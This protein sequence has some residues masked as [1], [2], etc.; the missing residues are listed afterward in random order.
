MNEK[1]ISI[2]NYITGK[3]VIITDYLFSTVTSPSKLVATSLAYGISADA[4]LVGKLGFIAF[5]FTNIQLAFGILASGGWL[6]V[7]SLLIIVSMVTYK[8]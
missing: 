4:L 2:L 8:K 3:L 7:I 1:F 6:A 5:L